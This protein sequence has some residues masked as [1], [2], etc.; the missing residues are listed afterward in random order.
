MTAHAQ[1][2]ILSV[3][4]RSIVDHDNRLLATGLDFHAD[5]S[6]TGIDRVFDQ[7]L[8][9]RSRPFHYLTGGD[10]ANKTFV[11]NTNGTRHKILTTRPRAARPAAGI[12][13]G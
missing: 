5:F 9:D 13:L 2:D 10:F 4:A 11:E 12:R 1:S 3:H 6:G 7:F 8:H